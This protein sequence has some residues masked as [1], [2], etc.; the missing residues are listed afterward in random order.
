MVEK[1]CSSEVVL[2]RDVATLA[3][4][5]QNPPA[6]GAEQVEKTVDLELNHQATISSRAN[7]DSTQP[8]SHQPPSFAI[9]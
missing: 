5:Q 1:G 2:F 3:R 4:Y 8:L 6:F 7:V 9:S